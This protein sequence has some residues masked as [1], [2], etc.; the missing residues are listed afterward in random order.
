[1]CKVLLASRKLAVVIVSN[2]DF[3][4]TALLEL[5]SPPSFLLEII[6]L[7]SLLVLLA[8]ALLLVVVVVE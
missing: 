5:F 7:L 3:V 6:V 8:V 4:I 1:L 2:T